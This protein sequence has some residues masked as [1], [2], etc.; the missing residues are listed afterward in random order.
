MSKIEIEARAILSAAQRNAT[1]DRMQA[2]G[3]VQKITRVMIDFSGEDRHRTVTLRIN[4]GLQE[5]VAKSGGLADN[6]RQEVLLHL[7]PESS[8][9]ASLHYFALMGY[10]DAMI[11]LRRMYVVQSDEFEYSLRDVLSLSDYSR[12]STL[13]DLEALKVPAGS[14]DKV[15]RKVDHELKAWGLEP[16]NKA[17][18]K[19]WVRE[20]YDHVDK[21]FSYSLQSA[22]DLAVLV[23]GAMNAVEPS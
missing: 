18:W 4:D 22:S 9:E 7:V 1:L 16:L 5:L 10:T 8:L 13:F 6:A 17:G 23:K 21:P 12:I 11:S 2:L 19:N 15:M 3:S 14:E 20:I